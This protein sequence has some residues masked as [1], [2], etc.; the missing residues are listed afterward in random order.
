MAADRWGGYNTQTIF[1]IFSGVL[2][3][4]LWLPGTS[5]AAVIVFAALYGFG[6]GAFV[7]VCPVLIA[8]ISPIQEIGMRNGMQFGVLAI[9]AL[10]SNPIGGAFIANNDGHYTHLKI[11]SG[12]VLLVGGSMY[13]AT[14]VMLAGPKLLK[15]I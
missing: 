10:I 3:L 15:K 9:P 7:T 11:W 1:S 14:R 5:N 2:V 6:S 12:V 4:A 8:Q 13:G